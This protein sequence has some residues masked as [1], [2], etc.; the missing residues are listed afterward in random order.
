M[1]SGEIHLV[2][3]DFW[4]NRSLVARIGPGGLLG[5]HMPPSPTDADGG[6]LASADS[7]VLFFQAGKVFFPL[8]VRLCVSP[9]SHSE[10][11]GG[12]G[13]KK[14]DAAGK[15]WNILPNGAPER[16]C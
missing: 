5:R 7:R 6:V 15:R 3:E 12:S 9:A 14:P 10:S 16:S 4:G 8:P 13:G 1:L 11:G 2:K